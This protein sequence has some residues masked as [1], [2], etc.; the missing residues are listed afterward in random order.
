MSK[1]LREKLMAH[2]HESYFKKGKGSDEESDSLARECG[3]DVNTLSG[4]VILPVLVSYSWRSG[5]LTGGSCYGDVAN[6]G[7]ESEPEDDF[8]LLDD[9]LE[10]H[11]PDLKFKDYRKITKLIKYGEYE[12]GEYYGNYTR[13][14]YKYILI[15]DLVKVLV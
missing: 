6:R 8:S 7:V 5:G 9:F 11:I 1:E 2:G 4:K 13:F 3:L 12:R 14:S 10:K 15:D